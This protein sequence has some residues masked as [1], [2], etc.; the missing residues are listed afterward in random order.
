L[1]PEVDPSVWDGVTIR[2]APDSVRDDIGKTFDQTAMIP[3]PPDRIPEPLPDGL[4]MPVVVSVQTFGGTRLDTPAPVQFP[5]LPD[6]V[7]GEL[8]QP[9]V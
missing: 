3:V 1:F 2:I 6:P 4:G 9:G 5:N 8:L 7:T